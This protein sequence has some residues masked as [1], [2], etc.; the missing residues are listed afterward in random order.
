[1]DILKI[2]EVCKAFINNKKLIDIYGEIYTRD[3]DGFF[4]GDGIETPY[5]F[6]CSA[7]M[8]I[9]EE[10]NL[11]FHQA[12]LISNLK[13]VKN[14]KTA[15]VYHMRDGKLYTESDVIMGLDAWEIGSKWKVVE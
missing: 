8:A 11:T 5:P 3:G 15:F 10:Y 13:R 14:E 1:M 7:N 9:Y 2:E 4:G 6:M 12:M